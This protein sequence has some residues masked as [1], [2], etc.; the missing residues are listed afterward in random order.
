MVNTRAKAGCTRLPRASSPPERATAT[1]PSTGSPTALRASP[2]MA[3]QVWVPAWAAILGG[4]IRL[5]APKN[6][7]N[8]VKPTR[9]RS[10]PSSRLSFSLSR[11]FPFPQFK[12][13][14]IPH[15]M[16]LFFTYVPK[17]ALG[18]GTRG[19]GIGAGTAVDAGTGIDDVVLVALGD[20]AHGAVAP[21]RHRNSRKRR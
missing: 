17:S 16:P 8:R 5:P 7:E 19:A 9:S 1:T 6:M 2:S 4:K 11:S 18:D 12:N 13:S 20:R 14:G 15:G 10:L 21:H 3:G